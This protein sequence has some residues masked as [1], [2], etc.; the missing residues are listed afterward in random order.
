MKVT[1]QQHTPSKNNEITKATVHV[2]TVY[3]IP[4]SCFNSFKSKR[5]KQLLTALAVAD[6]P[7][8]FPKGFLPSVNITST[9]TYCVQTAEP[10]EL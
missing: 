8:N 7:D 4:K 3:T 10:A 6:V 9:K 2:N 5:F 1:L